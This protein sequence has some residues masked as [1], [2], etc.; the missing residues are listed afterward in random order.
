MTVLA[1]LGPVLVHAAIL[2]GDR[3][4]LEF[5]VGTIGTPT[6]PEG[7]DPPAPIEGKIVDLLETI[8]VPAKEEGDPP[9]V[10]S[11]YGGALVLSYYQGVI[12]YVDFFLEK[13]MSLHST[14]G[15]SCVGPPIRGMPKLLHH[16]LIEG[17]TVI[18][19]AARQMN[20]TAVQ[21]AINKNES[22]LKEARTNAFLAALKDEAGLIKSKGGEHTPASY[23]DL[24]EKRI[25]LLI[26]THQACSKVSASTSP[27]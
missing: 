8:E 5:L 15:R 12:E 21:H 25:G 1:G 13:G 23:D 22:N 11:V 14:W 9:I 10:T 18:T 16:T 27:P 7:E 24:S 20:Q 17:D 2:T 19:A 6:A 26:G 3:P 4:G